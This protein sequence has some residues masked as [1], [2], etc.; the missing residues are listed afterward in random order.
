MT[1]LA[2]IKFLYRL[3]LPIDKSN[4]VEPEIPPEDL[5]NCLRLITGSW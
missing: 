3:P 5:I 4:T 1:F 2:Y